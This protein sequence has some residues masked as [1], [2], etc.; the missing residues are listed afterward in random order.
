[1]KV[2]MKPNLKDISGSENGVRRVIEAYYKYAPQF[3][4]DFVDNR[5]EADV[6]VAHAGT[7]GSDVD[8]AMLH[9]V[10]FTSDYEAGKWEYK[11]NRNIVNALRN[12]KEVTVP[13][14]WVAE[15][16]RRDA[17]INPH[18][19]GHGIDTELFT[20]SETYKKNT[21]LWNKNRSMD[22]CSPIPMNK[23]ADL[24]RNIKF[25]STFG[26]VGANIDIIGVIPHDKMMDLLSKTAVYLSTTKETFGIG[27]LEAHALGVPTLGFRYGGN[28]DI[29]KHKETGYLADPYNYG[30]LLEGLSYCLKN[31]DMLSANAIEHAKS[32]KWVTMVEKVVDVWKLSMEVEPPSV[33]VVIPTYNSGGKVIEAIK[34]CLDQRLKP[35]EIVVVDDGSDIS[36]VTYIDELKATLV[37]NKTNL[38]FIRQE[39][40]GVASARNTGIE[41]TTSKYICCLDNDDRISHDFLFHCVNEL[42]K[43]RSLGIA[44]TGITLID[45]KGKTVLGTWPVEF[46]YD[47][48]VAR[49]NR[50]PTCN[51]FRKVMWER[52]GGYK[53]RYCPN[54][55]GSEDAEFWLRAG[56]YGFNAKKVTNAGLFIYT[57]GGG[58]TKKDYQETNWTTFHPWTRDF[59]HPITSLA[60]PLNGM[61]HAVRQYDEPIISVVIPVGTGH[62]L[63][64]ENA[65]DSLEAQGIRK[66]E[67]NVVW[68]SKNDVPEKIKKAYP[69]IRI[70]KTPNPGSG[71]GVA[72]NVGVEN[73]RADTI[74][75][76]DADD[77]LYPDAL[78][79]MYN[80]YIRLDK[81][82]V[83]YTDYLGKTKLDNLE[84]ARNIKMELLDYNEKRKEAVFKHRSGFY[85]CKLA[86]DQPIRGET[87]YHWCLVTCMFNKRHHEEIGGFDETMDTFE[88]V[89]WHWRQSH[90]GR[91]YSR[92]E[93]PLVIYRFY[94]GTR[95]NAATS[96]RAVAKKHL[97]YMLEK[98]KAVEMANCTKCGGRNNK[99]QPAIENNFYKEK[100]REIQN[101]KIVD[102]SLVLSKY[103][104]KN[105]GNHMVMGGITKIRYGYKKG[106]DIFLVDKRDIAMMP[107]TFEVLDIIKEEDVLSVPVSKEVEEVKL[108]E[109]KLEEVEIT[110]EKETLA[111]D[112]DVS[113]LGFLTKYVN[114]L[115]NNNINMVSD[116]LSIKVDGLVKLKGI[117]VKMAN[118]IY[119]KSTELLR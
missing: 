38:I 22:V 32:F 114:I 35:K 87:P 103:L 58:T 47:L 41:K 13:S 12:A 108:E 31:R 8:V 119:H 111:Q 23:L 17:R 19:I 57:L 45:S 70:F 64:I 94:T 91:C 79:K 110:K 72:R 2:M 75:F 25:K 10:Y 29:I 55:Q 63:L 30:D 116:V 7:T 51:V 24:A 60:K 37:T 9:G 53:S 82:A 56:A 66:W 71:A 33:S 99:V 1:M 98:Y 74:V 6:F 15:V 46:D 86:Q 80:E 16:L 84:D 76:L 34:S 93:E 85:D 52:L 77:W 104:S 27:I 14:D 92:L 39:N 97:E 62:E 4:V 20:P 40:E 107:N 109:V 54:G 89:D 49:Q 96:D 69:Y 68:D 21:V 26:K 61:S 102:D 3:G 83:V 5:S 118:E 65:L 73:S 90:F 44:Y 78:E 101:Q 18:V 113:Q 115:K 100:V 11:A 50:I 117:G 88:D 28:I 36:E 42:E 67:A 95:R 106:G 105:S 81:D 48:Q 43:D 112:Y 59:Q